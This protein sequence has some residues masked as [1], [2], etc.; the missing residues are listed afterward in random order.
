MQL[1]DT[2]KEGV[3]TTAFAFRGYNITNLGRTPELLAHPTYG[4]TIA[5]V[6]AEASQTCSEVLGRPVDLPE[7]V[8]SARETPDLSSYAEDVALIVAAEVAQIR[9]LE[10][11]FSRCGNCSASRSPWRTTRWPWPPT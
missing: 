3:S 2:L 11:F 7:R 8:R 6:L 5:S 4:P 9:L 10:E 1:Q